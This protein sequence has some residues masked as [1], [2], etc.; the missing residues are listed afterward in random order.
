MRDSN[1]T[2]F[3]IEVISSILIVLFVCTSAPVGVWQG[4]NKVSSKQNRVNGLADNQFKNFPN[5]AREAL[6]VLPKG[7]MTGSGSPQQEKGLL[8]NKADPIGSD[9]FLARDDT[10]TDVGLLAKAPE[11]IAEIKKPKDG[12]R[13]SGEVQIKGRAT[14]PD[15]VNYTLSYSSSSDPNNFIL[16]GEYDVDVPK[17]GIL[18]T[19]QV[20]GLPD[21]DY[22]LKLEVFSGSGLAAQDQ[23]QVNVKNKLPYADITSPLDEEVVQS[24][25]NVIG[26]A[27]GLNIQSWLLTSTSTAP[28]LLCH[29][30][31]STIN[32]RT[33]EEAEITGSPTYTSAKFS[34][35]VFLTEGAGLTYPTS[36]KNEENINKDNGT[37]EMWIIPGWSGSD[38]TTRVLLETETNNRENPK[39]S[40]RIQKEE[41]S[42]VFYRYDKDGG[43][44]SC[45][46][47]VDDDTL[48]SGLPFHLAAVW[49]ED[50]SMSLYV[51]GYESSTIEGTGTGSLTKIGK[52][53][54]VGFYPG[55]GFEANAVFDDL[56]I[57][58][59]ARTNTSIWTDC[60]TDQPKNM[61]EGSIV[62]AEGDEP[63]ENS[64]ISTVNTTDAPGEALSLT[65]E[66]SNKKNTSTCEVGNLLID[67][68]SPTAK[69]KTPNDNE[70]ISG[71]VLLSGTAFDMDF[72]SYTLSYKVGND[73]ESS[74][75]WTEITTSTRQVWRDVLGSWNTVGL[76][77][78]FYTIRLE[79]VDLSDQ[80]SVEYVTVKLNN[81]D[82][83]AV[84][85]NP[86]S[87]AGLFNDQQQITGTAADRWFD[88]YELSYAPGWGEHN[89]EDW[90]SIGG[91]VTDPVEDGTLGTWDMSALELG[92]YTMKL[93]VVDKGGRESSCEVP[94][95]KVGMP[96]A[97][98]FF[99]SAGDL[100]AGIIEIMGTA[101]EPSFSSFKIDVAPGNPP[102][103][104]P[105][106]QEVVPDTTTSVV[107][108]SLG[109]WNT[110]GLS[111]DYTIRLTVKGQYGQVVT[112]KVALDLDNTKP[113]AS[114]NDP[115][116]NDVISENKVITGIATD[117]NFAN[118]KVEYG[119]GE[120]P[121]EWT[122]IGDVHETPVEGG[123]LEELNIELLEDGIY[124]I[125]LTVTDKCDN[126]S[127]A[128]VHI[129][130]STGPKFALIS[131]SPDHAASGDNNVLVELSGKGFA[132]N[133][134]VGFL[135]IEGDEYK[136]GRL[137]SD[138]V[139][140]ENGKKINC[141]MDLTDAEPGS[142]TVAVLNPDNEEIAWLY[143]SF[144]VTPPAPPKLS[145]ITPDNAAT[146]N[147]NVMITDLA[148]TNLTAVTTIKLTKNGQVDILASD[149]NAS[150]STKVECIL[151][152]TGADIGPW[153]V[154]VTDKYGQSAN[155]E[156]AFTVN[157]CPTVSSITPSSAPT[158]EEDVF[159]TE[160][161]GTNFM[162][163]ASIALVKNAPDTGDHLEIN[164]SDISVES[165]T[166]IT[167]NFDLSS[168]AMG[169]WTV[170]VTNPD[171][172]IGQLAM[173]FSVKGPIPAI[174]SITPDNA[175]SGDDNVQITE[176]A[177]I[178]FLPG[179][180]VKLTKAGETD[181]DA[182]DIDISLPVKISCVFD[183]T[184]V[185]P[186]TWD[187]VVINPDG[188]QDTM[189]D[190]FTIHQ[191]PAIDSITPGSAPSGNSSVS[192]TDLAG[193]NFKSGAAVKLVKSGHDDI[194][195]SDVNVESSGKITCKLDLSGAATGDWTVVVTNTDGGVVKLQDGFTVHKPSPT[196]TSLTP[197]NVKTGSNDVFISEIN[198]TNFREGSTVKITKQ[199]E[200]AIEATNV[201][202]YSSNNITC[203]L[204]LD[205]AT[206][207]DWNVVI[208]NDDGENG[209]LENG[210]RVL[211]IPTITSITPNNAVSGNDNV[212]IT[213]LS[214]TG[215]ESGATVK[216]VKY[217]PSTGEEI[218]IN[219]T[220]VNVDSSTKI[221]CNFDLSGVT[222]GSWAVLVTNPDSGSGSLVNG[223]K[224]T[225]A[226]AVTS[227]TPNEAATGQENVSITEIAGENF[228]AGASVKLEKSSEDDINA[229]E[230]VV[231]SETKITC[232]L[233]LSA[234]ASGAWNVVVT[235]GD[236]GNDKLEGGLVVTQALSVTS[237]TPNEVASASNN[238]SITAIAGNNFKAGASVRLRKSGQY[239][240]G[241]TDIDVESATKI[242]CKLDLSGVA[243]GGWSV[244]VT[245]SDGDVDV[246]ED[247]FNVTAAASD[248]PEASITSPV[249][250][251]GT[252]EACQV[253]G[254]AAGG[255]FTGYKLLC[256]AGTDPASEEAWQQIGDTQGTPVED[257]LLGTW[258]TSSLD[259]G[260]YLLKLVVYG[261]TDMSNA[262]IIRV[263]VDHTLPVALISKPEA[264]QTVS[265]LVKVVGTVSD[266]NLSHYILEYASTDNPDTWIKISQKSSVSINEDLLGWWN[267]GALEDGDYAL[268]LTA[269]DT[270]GHTAACTVSLTVNNLPY[271]LTGI[272]TNPQGAMMTVDESIDVITVGTDTLGG[273]HLVTPTYEAIGDVCTIDSD[274]RLVAGVV[275]KGSVTASYSGFTYQMPISVVEK[276]E[277]TVLDRDTVWTSAQN[278]IVVDGW[279]VVPSGIS[280]TIQPGT[281]IKFI[282][283][284]IYVEGSLTATDCILTSIAD[285]SETTC[286]DT[287]ANGIEE[288][289][290]H[291]WSAVF[292][293]QGS[294][295]SIFNVQFRYG[296]KDTDETIIGERHVKCKSE[297][298]SNKNQLFLS[299]CTFKDSE[300]S[301]VISTG[302][303]GPV[304]VIYNNFINC[305]DVGVL[306]CPCFNGVDI[307][308][309][310]ISGCGIGIESALPGCLMLPNNIDALDFNCLI[311]PPTGGTFTIEN[312]T[313]ISGTNTNIG[314]SATELYNLGIC[315]LGGADS[316]SI[317]DNPNISITINAGTGQDSNSTAYAIGILAYDLNSNC[318]FDIN[319]NKIDVLISEEAA[320]SVETS[321]AVGIMAVSTSMPSFDA[322]GDIPTINIPTIGPPVTVNDNEIDVT[323][324][325]GAIEGDH[326]A[327]MTLG[328][329]A[330][331]LGASGFEASRNKVNTILDGS[332]SE[333]G[334]F[335]ANGMITGSSGGNVSDNEINVSNNVTSTK[336]ISGYTVGLLQTCAGPEVQV[337][338]NRM[339]VESSDG[340]VMGIMSIDLKETDALVLKDNTIDATSNIIIY[341]IM[342]M[343]KG[344]MDISGNSLN[345]KADM[346]V[347]GISLEGQGPVSVCDNEL[348]MSYKNTAD[349]FGAYGIIAGVSGSES[350]SLSCE[351]NII[352]TDSGGIFGVDIEGTLVSIADNDISGFST[353]TYLQGIDGSIIGN[354]FTDNE[355]GLEVSGNLS[356]D[357]GIAINDNSISGISGMQISNVSV[358]TARGNTFISGDPEEN[359]NGAGFVLDNV[360][361]ATVEGNRISY[362]LA[363][364][365]LV[366]CSDSHYVNNTIES[367]EYGIL[368]SRSSENL[369]L[370]SN[371]IQYN[372]YFGLYS[373]G[374][375]CLD[376]KGNW[377]GSASGP[378]PYGFGNAVEGP[379]YVEPWMSQEE[380]YERVLS[381]PMSIDVGKSLNINTGNFSNNNIDVEVR[382]TRPC[383]TVD[384]TYNSL[385]CGQSG[386]FGNGW[387][388]TY[389]E[390]I[391]PYQPPGSSQDDIL[392]V[393]AAGDCH[394]YISNGDGTF[395]PEDQDYSVLTHNA[396]D[397]T[398]TLTQKDGS[399]NKY[400]IAGN[401]IEITDTNSNT[402]IVSRDEAKRVT[403]V[404]DACGQSII[405]TYNSSGKISS[406]EAP[407][408]VLVSYSY[409][410]S[411]NL[412]QFTDTDGSKWTYDYDSKNRMIAV[413]DPEYNTIVENEYDD[414]NRVIYQWDAYGNV[415]GFSYDTANRESVYTD[416]T[417]A[418]TTYTYDEKL[419]ETEERDALGNEARAIYDDDGNTTAITDKEGNNTCFIYDSSGN[420]ICETD[421]LGYS[422]DKT[423]DSK[424]NVLSEKDQLGEVATNIYDSS[425]NLLSETD[426][427]GQTTTHVYDSAGREI[428]KTTPRGATT[429]Y[430]YDSHGNIIRE[431]RPDG[432][433]TTNIYNETNKLTST[434]D[435]EGNITTF[436]Y[437]QQGNLIVVTD[438]AGNS[439]TYEY[440][441]NGNKIS[442]TDA[443]G[444]T[445]CAEYDSIGRISSSIDPMKRRTTYEYDANGRPVKTVFPNGSKTY[446][447]Y[448]KIGRE[449][450]TVD[451]RG[452]GE[453]QTFDNNGSVLT[454]TNAEENTTTYKYDGV[455]NKILETDPLGNESTYCYDATGNLVSTI[456]PLGHSIKTT[457]D[458]LGREISVKDA[459][460]NETWYSYDDDNRKVTVTDPDGSSTTTVF[461]VMGHTVAS[462]DSLGNTTTFTYDFTDKNT[463]ITDAG[464]ST[465]RFT[466]NSTGQL[467]SVIDSLGNTVSYTYDKAGRR[468]LK[469]NPNGGV[470]RYTYDAAG[471]LILEVNPIGEQIAYNYDDMGRIHT[472]TDGKGTTTYSYDANGNKTKVSYPDGQV[473]T[474]IYNKNNLPISKMGSGGTV[475]ISYDKLDRANTVSTGTSSMTATYDENG[476][477]TGKSLTVNGN[478]KEFSYAY[479]PSGKMTN[480]TDGQGSSTYTYTKSGKLDSKT[481]PNGIT[482]A[483]TYNSVGALDSLVISGSQQLKSYSITRDTC[484][485]ITGITEDGNQLTTYN[486]DAASRLIEENSPYTG[487]TTYTYDA[488]G[489]RTSKVVQGEQATTYIYNGA[490]ELISD[491]IGHEYTY[492]SSG[493]LTSVTNGSYAKYLNWDGK[494]RLSNVADTDGLSL[495]YAYDPQDR[496]SSSME[497]SVITAYAY[498]MTSDNEMATIDS[499]LNIKDL[500]FS[501]ADGLISDT[502]SEGTSYYSFNPHGDTSL[503]TDSSGVTISQ[504][505]YDAWGNAIEATSEPN[506]YLGK[507]QRKDYSS[508]NLIKMG[509]RYYDP[510]TGRFISR[511]PLEGRDEI[512][513]SHNQYAYTYGD[514]VNQSDIN[515]MSPSGMSIRE[516]IQRKVII[517]AANRL[518]GIPY[519]FG[520]KRFPWGGDKVKQPKNWP[521]PGDNDWVDGEEH[522]RSDD[523]GDIVDC[524]NDRTWSNV[525]KEDRGYKH[526]SVRDQLRSDTWL[527]PRCIDCSGLVEFAYFEA[528][529]RNMLRN[530]AKGQY[531]KCHN[532]DYDKSKARPG[533]LAFI[534]RGNDVPHVAI[535]TGGKNKNKVI[536]AL[537]AGTWVTTKGTLTKTPLLCMDYK[538]NLMR[539]YSDR[540]PSLIL[541]R[542]SFFAR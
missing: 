229:T 157:P 160:I 9:G 281:V 97:E 56:S 213:D 452:N 266:D 489:N 476:Y 226:P 99:P 382:G 33:N 390:R 73:P 443:E 540:E 63:V 316:Y 538:G 102:D 79:T 48:P 89:S 126:S 198:G 387:S 243:T 199:G 399:L 301:G 189:K 535:F 170:V 64:L 417:G 93:Y 163:G 312:N 124:T 292:L 116:E 492:N 184:G 539:G 364:L 138:V 530:N 174:T 330:G 469:T 248:L 365:I 278:P 349:S 75:D 239:D 447:V 501:G 256:K 385:K 337:A 515:G 348:D 244:V 146:G 361:G 441:A 389:S 207:G 336:L 212:T 132:E 17:K 65:L 88:Y 105:D 480:A 51:N 209:K 118:Y 219:A 528:G 506:N 309:N 416:A 314:Q 303:V 346:M 94:V 1:P 261:S 83:E 520:G 329:S 272:Q 378:S 446:F 318:G 290:S 368:A 437:D 351:S 254:T 4:V 304:T 234:A 246:L 442:E 462:V 197:D 28:R 27:I 203:R 238:V 386:P 279:I 504:V 112:D 391:E 134:M 137:A 445:S 206:T 176:I 6:P 499:N 413:T 67:N 444:N 245:N 39:N 45:K 325:E 113:Q 276:V 268:R 15:F 260:F 431:I 427:I 262:S 156:N 143:N 247:G 354:I 58:N 159:T 50:A 525:R 519:H 421:P 11:T 168:A 162:S 477:I 249:E 400:D 139:V 377:W 488:N 425:N 381:D 298:Y 474:T 76:P 470:T 342:S 133:A 122:M 19:W 297:L 526:V 296:G 310:T 320:Q 412:I 394:R 282:S 154:V 149:I 130:V 523:Y 484:S 35:G 255:S 372:N 257:G 92:E 107:G 180:R 537:M 324:H 225:S 383:I 108:G 271:E 379:V 101:S 242:T 190:C 308:G 7:T 161:A 60:L 510:E 53:L 456:D 436:A 507:Y 167:C 129:E 529:L 204:D 141:D 16:I 166:K 57:Y 71:E 32:V 453:W 485:K 22:F 429:T 306:A 422:V 42:I 131:I 227:I 463:S 151:D 214:G 41:G 496:V 3:F 522:L 532:K 459:E 95:L 193:S 362:Y 259:E 393:N 357:V 366:D 471:M 487:N 86:A 186:G 335:M 449:I 98:V 486:Y 498:D 36:K 472:E 171:G 439:R 434:T 478:T 333:S 516:W 517:I 542:P 84:I 283:G 423:Y 173:G 119:A 410:S 414:D 527:H 169:Y 448:D 457:Y 69:I 358:L 233:N 426:Q 440:D 521:C 458:A 322:N 455:G 371:N 12:K 534:V 155:L 461:D 196:I 467:A 140:S 123:T 87:Q 483:Y 363:G 43:A 479:S 232:R 178:K 55:A 327:S 172:G 72:S 215:F 494:G 80:S 111:G 37:I 273:F 230:V 420:V 408:N 328:I 142:W 512:V 513:M 177:G 356:E 531:G 331:G 117:T 409:D 182:V 223:F 179:A 299:G 5:S 450:A 433:I 493:E 319:R 395:R 505:H 396:E 321:E 185:S 291:R 34:E 148:G 26:T 419:H 311:N 367:N 376:A 175:G 524:K 47:N 82:P 24:S 392:L 388:Y 288:T 152:L 61:G 2:Q 54:Y 360:T 217:N 188:G 250:N 30:D 267:T 59:Y 403:A 345:A 144:T 25:F 235:N 164:A 514:P 277:S 251:G 221:T 253:T 158:D 293:T 435:P 341:G 165:A 307:D 398:W 127:T 274:G 384:R 200:V 334:M 369:H 38:T 128:L 40:M 241:A 286:G 205:E 359:D 411:G 454:E 405:F 125:K 380:W 121:T 294:Q 236:G 490:D 14:C 208:T 147:K 402:C 295:S 81:D 343:N 536:E 406:I 202:V 21:G 352:K 275:G 332:S 115:A 222:P 231:E 305:A 497:N 451:G 218:E 481:Y 340:M 18:G 192:I 313:I 438:P 103:D 8:F 44:R 407:G 503:M 46:V 473:E 315:I 90:V 106:W 418:D 374:P 224:V 96:I 344:K 373:E 302:T 509:V 482:T 323:L 300:G 49:R 153:N 511:D 23:I 70:M 465:T 375:D 326:P 347:N 264:S 508:A 100:K 120:D 195:A 201:T 216:L 287:N 114:I 145:S 31:N 237:I 541:R 397:G 533:D 468:V 240:V 183:L 210:F 500:Y 404:A 181:I 338:S 350:E 491:S 284:G 20:G 317:N 66:A 187:L 191:A 464:G 109:T 74:S 518:R 424:G 265:G 150:S 13:V 263:D 339:T 252:A 29:F 220:D 77:D 78:N 475:A 110:E 104:S 502:N 52:D 430:E 270:A 280:L 62:R 135:L 10:V 401:I 460:D 466:Y 428:S 269:I 370:S 415:S 91:Q 432:G 68:P 228:K 289:T 136:D 353:G 285:D 355:I 85:T 194:N 211:S 258:D 495:S